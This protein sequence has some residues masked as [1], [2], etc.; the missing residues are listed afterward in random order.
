MR[1][2]MIDPKMA[3]LKKLLNSNDAFGVIKNLIDTQKI[4]QHQAK[5]L[6]FN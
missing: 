2:K 5:I 4:T 6:L 3:A 1:Y